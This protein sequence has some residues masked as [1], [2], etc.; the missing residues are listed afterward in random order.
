MQLGNWVKL[1]LD[2]LYDGIL[3]ANKDCIV[4]YVN[5]S[6][7]RITGV[8]YDEIVG[9]PLLEVRQTKPLASKKEKYFSGI[10]EI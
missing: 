1:I 2:S 3:I 9:K 10:L 7:T 6:Y 4:E 8:R 5:P